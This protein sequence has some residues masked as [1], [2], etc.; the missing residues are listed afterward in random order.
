MGL[1]Q[2]LKV[3]KF[4]YMD[5]CWDWAMQYTPGYCSETYVSHRMVVV[6]FV[7][8]N[9]TSVVSGEMY[10]LQCRQ[11]KLCKDAEIWLCDVQLL[12]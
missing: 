12:I 3:F 10:H 8:Y 2:D 11:E 7:G 5:S 9:N 4:R 6:T 1:L